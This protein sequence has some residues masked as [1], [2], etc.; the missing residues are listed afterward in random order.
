[1]LR[2]ISAPRLQAQLCRGSHADVFESVAMAW[3]DDVSKIRDCHT[4][5]DDPKSE[6]L[7]SMPRPP[8][9]LCS[10]SAFLSG[11][12]PAVHAFAC[13]TRYTC[14][15]I[16]TPACRAATPGQQVNGLQLLALGVCV[17]CMPRC[18]MQTGHIG[19][20]LCALKHARLEFHDCNALTAQLRILSHRPRRETA[21][22][23]CGDSVRRCSH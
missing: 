17:T 15:R 13:R 10:M 19:M 12:R 14:V 4:H 2:R 5:H 1:M 18:M 21:H 16:S 23:R 6:S 3:N 11:T 8:H 22:S 20:S 9:V 7:S